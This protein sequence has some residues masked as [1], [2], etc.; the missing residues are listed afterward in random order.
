MIGFYMTR[1]F[2]DVGHKKTAYVDYN[3]L[4]FVSYLDRYHGSLQS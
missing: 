1:W 4:E 3:Q 2:A